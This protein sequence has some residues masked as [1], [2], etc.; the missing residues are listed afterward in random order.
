M[1]RS[2]IQLYTLRNVEKPVPELL[3]IVADAGFEGVEFY[4]RV[5]D[6]DPGAV[7]ETMAETGLEAAGSHVGIERL[8]DDA[9]EAVSVY[10]DLGCEHL[11]APYLPEEDFRTREAVEATAERLE[12]LSETLAEHGVAFHY[13]THAHEFTDLGDTTGYEYLIELADDVGFQL[14]A[15]TAL[16]RGQDPADLLGRLGD[17]ATLFHCKD[18]DVAADE[19]APAGEG[20]LDVEACA[21]ATREVGTEWFIYEYEGE[22]PLETV[23]D[24]ADLINGLL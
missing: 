17:R 14:D 5:E 16:S 21:K 24:A 4:G 19:S 7:R 2:A 6:A 1:V 22:D 3:E 18:Y 13:H 12:S 23:E 20:D 9:G 11:T 15:G 8:E 10:G